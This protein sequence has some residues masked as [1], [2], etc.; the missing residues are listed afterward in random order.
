MVARTQLAA[1]DFNLGCNLEQAKTKEGEYR[2]NVTFSKMT[3]NWSAKPIKQEKS[4]KVFAKLIDRSVEAI[5]TGEQISGLEIPEL[6]KNIASIPKPDKNDVIENQ[7]TR[8]NV[9]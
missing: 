1:I 7:K 4:L 2:Y 6:P 9:E 3:Q 5:V 8:F